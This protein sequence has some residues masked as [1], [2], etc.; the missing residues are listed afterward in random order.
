MKKIFIF[1][2]GSTFPNIKE[3]WGDFDDFVIR[4]AN[5]KKE[6]VEVVDSFDSENFGQINQ[7][8]GVIITGSHSNVTEEAAWMNNLARW[9][10]QLADN[11]IPVL[12]ICFGHQVLAYAFGGQV[13]NN[14]EGIEIGT[15][16]VSLNNNAADDLLLNK[17]PASFPGH[18]SHKQTVTELPYN[19]I[20]LASSNMES[21]QAVCFKKDKIWGLQ[22]H[23]EFNADVTRLYT[24][25][26]KNIVIKDGFN[27]DEAYESVYENKFGN[28]ILDRFVEICNES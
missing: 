20:I 1:K 22:F 10:R 4:E 6:Q 24:D 7:V 18:V 14:P 28:L 27:F 5:L 26:Q 11:N 23:P 9:I 25:A 13:E 21:F 17:M 12:G 19:A 8:S 15:V 3:K 16:S 2:T